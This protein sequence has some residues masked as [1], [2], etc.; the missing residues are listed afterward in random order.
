MRQQDDCHVNDVLQHQSWQELGRC[1]VVSQLEPT[2]SKC[3]FLKCERLTVGQER[4]FNWTSFFEPFTED[5]VVVQAELIPSRLGKV[6][7]IFC[8]CTRRYNKALSC[9]SSLGHAI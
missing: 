9:A 8:E 5:V 3:E 6:D 1:C 2:F 7:S 4:S